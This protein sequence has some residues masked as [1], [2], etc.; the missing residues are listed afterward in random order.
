MELR[1]FG[2]T[3]LRVPVVGMGT[4]QTFD[5]RGRLADS[6]REVTDAAF[7]A[8]ATFFDSS[9]MYGQAE[10]V[11]GRTLRGRRREA[12]VATKVWTSSDH[13]AEEQIAHSLHCFGGLVDILQVHNLVAWP[14]RVARL[15][16]LKTEGAVHAVGVTHYSK[17]ALSELRRAMEDPRVDVIQ[18]PYN[19][20]ERAVETAILPA[21]A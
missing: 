19:P 12:L 11:L 2:R 14:A 18:I 6:R 13:E 7:A 20:L 5:V 8:G 15:D 9:P 10:E 17:G 3:T 16:R 21:A 4:W 1:Q